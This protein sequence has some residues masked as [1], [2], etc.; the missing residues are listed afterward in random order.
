MTIPKPTS[1]HMRSSHYTTITKPPSC[2]VRSSHYTTITEF[3]SCHVRSSRFM[4]ITK[5]ITCFLFF[6]SNPS[7]ITYLKC[8]FIHIDMLI[9]IDM[10][11]D[12]DILVLIDVLMLQRA[13]ISGSFKMCQ[14][15]VE[16]KLKDLDLK[17]GLLLLLQMSCIFCSRRR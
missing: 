1:C 8:L 7:T 6:L 11:I 10:L 4:T 5:F 13:M 15:K 12:S 14:L 17:A 2:H 3:P 9:E 16:Q